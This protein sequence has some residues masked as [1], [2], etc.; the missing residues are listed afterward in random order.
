MRVT[1]T[2]MVLF[3]P[4]TDS[5]DRPIPSD[6]LRIRFDLPD[7][8]VFTPSGEIPM[9]V[10]HFVPT[11]PSSCRLEYLAR[12]PI[13]IGP[14]LVWSKKD[15]RVFAEDRLVLESAQTWYDKSSDDFERSVEA[16]AAPLL[17]RRIAALAGRS[18]WDEWRPKLVQRRV[19]D[20]RA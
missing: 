1:E 3:A 19:I 12:R 16:D 7:R 9:I 15:S 5:G 8:I 18:E 11:G 14:K 17:A 10:L 13:P 20:V 2:G 4:V 6:A